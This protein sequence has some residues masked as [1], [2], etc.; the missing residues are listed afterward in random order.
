MEKIIILLIILGLM[1]I[2]LWFQ[3]KTIKELEATMLLQ[4]VISVNHAKQV[5]AYQ[6]QLEVLNK[7]LERLE[8]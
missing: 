8:K 3:L 7:Y 5:K 4:E 6:E 1:C 2:T